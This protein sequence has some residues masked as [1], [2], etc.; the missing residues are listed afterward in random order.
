MGYSR[1]GAYIYTSLICLCTVYVYMHKYTSI[2]N[3]YIQAIE[4]RKY[5]YIYVEKNVSDNVSVG[6]PYTH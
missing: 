6:S 1:G 3:A 4:T 5:I 2:Y